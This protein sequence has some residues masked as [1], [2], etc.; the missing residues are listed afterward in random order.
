MKQSQSRTSLIMDGHLGPALASWARG[1]VGLRS[2]HDWCPMIRYVFW[3]EK[4]AAF[5]TIW[6][7]SQKGERNKW[8]TN[9][10]LG[11][12][13]VPSI[14]LGEQNLPEISWHPEV[15]QVQIQESPAFGRLCR[16]N[17]IHLSCAIKWEWLCAILQRPCAEKK[18][19]VLPEQY[20]SISLAGN[21]LGIKEVGWSENDGQQN[22]GTST[23]KKAKISVV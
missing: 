10:E 17:C 2:S 4:S 20:D 3:A 16:L 14:I 21:I 7:G 12:N 11:T 13:S 8:V 23:K 6:K 19:N 9:R 22:R 18:T 5:V 1:L 15:C